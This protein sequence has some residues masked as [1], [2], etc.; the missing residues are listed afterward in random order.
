MEKCLHALNK[1]AN[2]KQEWL[3]SY[4]NKNEVKGISVKKYVTGY[5]EWCAE[6]YMET[7]YDKLTKEDFEKTIKNYIS[8][9]FQNGG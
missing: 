3:Q 4:I 1:W 5:D 2:I 8:F 9:K 7:D 6:A